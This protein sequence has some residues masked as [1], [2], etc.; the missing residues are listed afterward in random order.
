MK[1]ISQK[2]VKTD[3]DHEEM[4]RIEFLASLYINEQGPVIPLTWVDAT[5]VGAAKK[6]KEGMLA[7][8]GVFC[9][10]NSMLEYEGP[11]TPDALWID[12]NFRDRS[13]VKVGTAR[14]MRTRPVFKSWTAVVEV[15]VDDSIVNPDRLSDWFKIAGRYLGFGD[16]RPQFGRFEATRLT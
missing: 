12:D 8:S 1:Q 7:K 5:L 10:G 2:R 13:L 15:S 4:A 3:A 16:W 11:R 6:N 14:V 9:E